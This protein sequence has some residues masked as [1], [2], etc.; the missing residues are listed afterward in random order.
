MN[1]NKLT[2]VIMLYSAVND[3]HIINIINANI[4]KNGN[5]FNNFTFEPTALPKII[6]I[7]PTINPSNKKFVSIG[8]FSYKNEIT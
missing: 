6:G 5:V 7:K 3:I 1:S 8:Y 2:S 4:A